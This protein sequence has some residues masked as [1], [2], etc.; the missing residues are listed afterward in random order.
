MADQIQNYKC[1]ACTGPLHFVGKSGKLECDY[2]GSTYTIAE[3]EALYPA[4][5][6][7]KPAGKTEGTKPEKPK[8]QTAESS[9]DL[10]GLSDDWGDAAAGMKVHSCPSC[11]AELFCEET[12]AATAC[13]YCGNQ[14]VISD[15]LDGTL[16]PDYVIPFKLSHEDAESALKKFYGGKRLLPRVFS[17]Q[18]TIKEV[19]GIYVPFWLFDGSV[20]G[21]MDFQTSRSVTRREGDYRVTEV[22]HYSVHRGGSMEFQ[23]IPVD[24]SSK[25]PDEH[26][27]SL[28]PYDYQELKPFSRAYL[29]GYLADKYDVTAEQSKRRAD[30]R[31]EQ[32]IEDMLSGSVTGYTSKSVSSRHFNI[33]RGKVSYG[34]LPVYM[35]TTKWNDKEYLFAVNGQTGKIV[36]NLPVDV[37]KLWL[38]RLG[39]FAGVTGVLGTVLS[40]LFI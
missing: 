10:S 14:T 38:W 35:L 18:N 9:W 5:E 39:L 31:A 25:M 40:M 37:K 11:G 26:M 33:R 12:T 16:R 13:P 17:S 2:C 28:E 21:E 20:R 24:A 15:N 23:K 30:K 7:V 29:P 27:D 1:P 34:L 19:K 32:S 8:G 6:T 36:G 3:I 22:S 4:E